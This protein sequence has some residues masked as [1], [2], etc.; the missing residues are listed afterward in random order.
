VSFAMM[1]PTL[2][3]DDKSR[4][5]IEGGISRRGYRMPPQRLL[6]NRLDGSIQ[7][8]ISRAVGPGKNTPKNPNHTKIWNHAALVPTLL[9]NDAIVNIAKYETAKAMKLPSYKRGGAAGGPMEVHPVEDD[10]LNSEWFSPAT[11]KKRKH[12]HTGQTMNPRCEYK[13]ARTGNKVR[14]QPK[15]DFAGSQRTVSFVRRRLWE[16]KYYR[17]Q[18]LA[19]QQSRFL[20]QLV[21]GY[22]KMEDDQGYPAT[23]DNNNKVGLWEHLNNTLKD[24]TLQRQNEWW[25]VDPTLSKWQAFLLEYALQTGEL[26]NQHQMCAH[27]DRSQGHI[28]E[29]MMLI[30]KCRLQDERD[31]STIARELEANVGQLV[32]ALEQYGYHLRPGRDAIHA[33]FTFTVHLPDD[34][35]GVTN[36]SK[37]NHTRKPASKKARTST[38]KRK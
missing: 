29:T 36:Y 32:C 21:A 23:L 37:V 30:G 26:I 4:K 25:Q 31:D 11:K 5:S 7:M 20:C 6:Q 22:H 28:L 2:D 1:E 14:R 19:L 34:S 15:L 27:R 17:A 12:E 9:K 8:G 33:D 10:E 35:R 38:R 18:T 3:N 16:C 24:F 13:G